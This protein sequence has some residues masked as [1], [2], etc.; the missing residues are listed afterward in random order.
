MNLPDLIQDAV[1]AGRFVVSQHAQQRLRQRRVQLWQVEAGVD[2]WT[3]LEVRPQDLPNPSIVCE[4]VLPDG[5]T[6]T[7]IWAWDVTNSWALLVTV[8]FL[9]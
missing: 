3:V 2:T 7:V 1:R 8:Y 9:N 6:I 5:T 4:Q